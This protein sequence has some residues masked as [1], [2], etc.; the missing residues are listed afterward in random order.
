M[1][2]SPGSTRSKKS[3]SPVMS[4]RKSKKHKDFSQNIDETVDREIDDADEID[5]KEVRCA[6]V[7]GANSLSRDY[8]N[9]ENYKHCFGKNLDY[10]KEE[11]IERPKIRKTQKKQYLS[12]KNTTKTKTRTY[13]IKTVKPKPMF[14]SMDSTPPADILPQI[15]SDP[16][17]PKSPKSPQ[18]KSEP[19]S[20]KSPKIKSKSNSPRS[21]QGSPI[22]KGDMPPMPQNLSQIV[23]PMYNPE[24]EFYFYSKSANALPGKGSKE[25]LPPELTSEYEE[26]AQIPDWRKKLS[27]FAE[28]RFV[29]DGLDWYSVEHY[30]QASK[31]KE[32][33]PEF[34]YSFSLNSKSELS[35]NSAMAKAAGGKTGKYEKKQIRPKEIEIDSTFFST[36]RSKEEM[37]KAQFEKFT[38][39]PE[40]RNLLLA[41]KNANLLHIVQRS[42][43]VE[44]FINLIYF[45]YLM[46]H[47]RL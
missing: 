47:G 36:S 23:K 40:M 39:V 16:K 45:R 46:Q 12:S 37:Y 26:L 35:T 17:S 25:K 41:T 29:L 9:Y 44:H 15:K 8:E 11:R 30:Y 5:C 43:N 42:S 31:F 1:T 13:H 4:L 33:T 3:K 19:K 2:G 32:Q 14:I 6:F 24:I 27:N 7:K 20:P 28:A 34:Y 38:Q 18:I 22:P 21:K 10:V